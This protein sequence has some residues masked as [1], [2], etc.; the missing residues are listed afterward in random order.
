MASWFDKYAVKSAQR[1]TSQAAPSGGISRRRVLVGG[2]AAVATAWTAPVLLASSAAAAVSCPPP[3]VKTVCTDG[4]E[5]CCPAAVKDGPYT[6]DTVNDAECIAPGEPGGECTNQGQGAG[7]CNSTAYKCNSMTNGK[8][9]NFCR[10]PHICGGEGA[11]CFSNNDC[12]GAP[13]NAVCTGEGAKT[14]GEMFCRRKCT[15]PG[16][17]TTGRYGGPQEVCDTS[18]G[19][20]AY[21]CTTDNDCQ[22]AA[23]RCAPTGGSAKYCQ[24]DQ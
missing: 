6:C 2:S 4:G 19:F 15:A 7:G 21:A 11:Q 18:T 16:G 22:N 9:C 8:G 17:C 10:T 20:C 14:P 5:K 13:T 23:G 24:Y 1:A 12:F 3:S